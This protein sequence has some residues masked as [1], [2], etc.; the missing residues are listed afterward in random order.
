MKFNPRSIRA[1]TLIELLVVIAIIAIL[2]AML[3]PAL[4]RAKSKAR[5]ISCLNNIRQL[6]ACSALYAAE[7]FDMLPPNNSLASLGSGNTLAAGASWCT[8]NARFD[9]SP[10]GIE[11]GLLYQYSR[12]LEIYRCPSD[13]STVESSSGQKLTERRRRSYNLSQSINGAPEMDPYLASFL[14]SF[15]KLSQILNPDPTECLTFIEVHEDSIYDALFGVPTKIHG[16]RAWWD[17]P[18]GRHDQTGIVGFADG[19]AELWRWRAPKVVLAR[20]AAQLIPDEEVPDFDR[21]QHAV[22]QGWE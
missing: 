18:S 21:V 8:N 2:A 6:G 11:N 13:F 15:K 14:P 4:S 16:S 17:V 12:S 20:N 22:R 19:H 1:F 5:T 7:F 3:L 9:P 10:A